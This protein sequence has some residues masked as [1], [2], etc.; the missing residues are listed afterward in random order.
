MPS[1]P[2]KFVDQFTYLGSNISSTESDVNICI[3]KARTTT[4]RL[5]TIRKSDLNDKI[6]K[7]FLQA[8]AE[9]VLLYSCTTWTLTKKKLNGNYTM[10]LRAVLNKSR[11][12]HSI[13]QLFGHLPPIIPTIQVKQAIRAGHC[14][15]RNH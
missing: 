14:R 2:L 6:K 1:M 5:T 8:V 15:R 9:S 10:I 7:G 4:D 11:K 3:D 12:Q 13:K